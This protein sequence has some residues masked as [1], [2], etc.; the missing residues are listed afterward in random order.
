MSI[1]HIILFCIA[2]CYIPFRGF[3]W[4]VSYF[5]LEGTDK[6]EETEQDTSLSGEDTS[7]AEKSAL[8]DDNTPLTNAGLTESDPSADETESAAIGDN[9]DY[10]SVAEGTVSYTA[11]EQ[12]GVSETEAAEEPPDEPLQNTQ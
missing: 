5:E 11:P 10:T 2:V 12:T 9:A 6:T 1:L 3:S 7:P 8:T 4:F